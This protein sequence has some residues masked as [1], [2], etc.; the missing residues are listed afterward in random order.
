M[1]IIKKQISLEPFTSRL[2]SMVDSYNKDGEKVVFASGTT[3]TNYGMLPCNIEYNYKTL[4]WPNVSERYH[5][6]VEYLDLLHSENP[7]GGKGD[8]KTAVE[9]AQ[10]FMEEMDNEDLAY[11]QGL[12]DTYQEYG[13]SAFTEFLFSKCVPRFPIPSEFQDA[14]GRDVLFY[15][16]VQRWIKVLEAMKEQE[17]GSCDRCRY[18]ELGGDKILDDLKEWL[19]ETTDFNCHEDCDATCILIP[20]LITCSMDDLGEFTAYDE[21]WEGGVDYSADTIVTYQDEETFLPE[22][23]YRVSGDTPAFMLNDDNCTYEFN[24]DGWIN[25][26]EAYFDCN[27]THCN[28]CD[29]REE[30]K[31]ACPSGYTQTIAYKDDVLKINPTPQEMCDEYDIVSNANGFYYIGN[32]LYEPIQ[33]EYVEYNVL[34]TMAFG[35]KIL[36]HDFSNPKMNMKTCRINGKT[37]YSTFNKN[38]GK[39]YF[40]FDKDSTPSEVKEGLFVITSSNQILMV[41]NKTIKIE[42]S[43]DVP[44]IY[45]SI[46]SYCIVNGVYHFFDASNTLKQYVKTEN[47]TH[48]LADEED[49][50][51][52]GAKLS[53]DKI[54]ENSRGYIVD[55]DKLH[56]YSPYKVYNLNCIEGET[57]SKLGNFI[58]KEVVTDDMGNYLQ[59]APIPY[60][61]EDY[62]N[63]SSDFKTTAYNNNRLTANS[64][65]D[66]PIHVGSVDKLTAWEKN[67]DDD[68]DT[69]I[70]EVY[71]G[72]IISKIEIYFKDFYGNKIEYTFDGVE[73]PFIKG[74][75]ED[76]GDY[77]ASGGKCSQE[78]WFD[79]KVYDHLEEILSLIDEDKLRIDENDATWF[80]EHI[81]MSST[82]YCDV[83]YNM[84]A[85][86][87]KKKSGNNIFY[88]E[89]SEDNYGVEYTETL[90]LE[91]HQQPYYIDYFNYFLVGYWLMKGQEKIIPL[92]GY[93][94]VYAPVNMA[95]F[96][97]ATDLYPRKH[98]ND[99]RQ[100]FDGLLTA[101]TFRE[102][103]KLGSSS[104]EKIERDVYIERGNSSCIEKHLVLMDVKSLEALEQ[105]GNGYFQINEN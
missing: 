2:P 58:S 95:K 1:R 28:S 3:I 19:R 20:L 44:I 6:I 74:L 37:F 21:P 57:E 98:A 94:D 91:Q 4:A 63:N 39:H 53:V 68:S 41:E 47:E 38:D 23:Y 83:T 26:T 7:C 85:I 22:I 60:P 46:P 13:G 48:D 87:Y 16:D 8:Y 14:W 70:A 33:G 99:Y 9:Y 5:F 105:Y 45:N 75:K 89:V 40:T 78:Q 86:I 80:K 65:L 102:Q 49:T 61:I 90:T 32:I 42:S 71:F 59:G 103:Y 15:T 62:T 81:S 79:R 76:N 93:N 84:G 50:I 12:D 56:V 100:S 64:T 101:P 97:V 72:N 18:E 67:S 34:D 24:K 82:I 52:F 51:P 104:L 55:N 31:K 11:Y 35:E 77:L 25:H 88:Y 92:N 27:E 54:D 73:T 43:L 30:Y 29:G 66:L 96:K 69:N 36:V 17:E 10:S